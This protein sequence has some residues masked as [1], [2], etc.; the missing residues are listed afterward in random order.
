ML[1]AKRI[2]IFNNLSERS[3]VSI[4]TKQAQKKLSINND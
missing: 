2:E 3:G 1:R 4:E